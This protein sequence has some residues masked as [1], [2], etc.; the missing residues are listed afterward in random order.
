MN[1]EESM[2]FTSTTTSEDSIENSANQ[3]VTWIILEFLFFIYC[4]MML[5]LIVKTHKNHLKPV[6]LLTLTL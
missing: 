3:L 6:H 2:N 4:L 5:I 1:I